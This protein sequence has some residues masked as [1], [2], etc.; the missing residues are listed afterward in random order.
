[1]ASVASIATSLRPPTARLPTSPRRHR[2]TQRTLQ[3]RAGFFDNF[4]KSDEAAKDAE[5]QRQQE[6]LAARR[7]GK[8][9]DK[10]L[11]RR[12]KLKK[13]MSDPV[14]REAAYKKVVDSKYI[15]GGEYIEKG[16]VEE[17]EGGGLDVSGMFKKLFKKG[18]KK[19]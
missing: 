14:K 11:E 15:P 16:W 6:V 2:T 9:L 3:V 13:D 12:E 7:S 10:A 5:F 4:G 17:T 8:S 19:N 18:K 1:M